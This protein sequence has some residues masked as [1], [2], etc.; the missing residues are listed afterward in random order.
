MLS[1][2]ASWFIFFVVGV[3]VGGWTLIKRRPHLAVGICAAMAIPAPTW[4]YIGQEPFAFD[5]RMALACVMLIAYCFHPLGTLRYPQH[6]LDGVVLAIIVIHIFSDVLHGGSFVATS[7]RAIGE[8]SVPYLAGR[9]A[10]LFRGG[11]TSLAP[12]FSASAI[13]LGMGALVESLTGANLWELLFSPMD[14]L[15]ERSRDLRYGLLYRAAGPTRHPIFLAIIL[16]LLLP[17]AVAQAERGTTQRLR[18]IGWLAMAMI[19][20]GMVATVSRGPL[21][22]LVLASLVATL[23]RWPR[24]RPFFAIGGVA[25]IVFLTLFGSLLITWMEKTDST[26]ERGKLVDI[27]DDTRVYTGTRNRLFVWEIYGPLVVRGGLFGFGTEAI[28]SFPPNIPGLPKTAQA[29]ETLGIVD[30]SYL[31]FGLRFGWVGLVLMIILL[32]GAIVTTI[33]QRRSAGLIFYP[34]G[35]AFATALAGVLAGVALE[36]TTVYF[37]YE[38]AYWVLFHCGVSTGLASLHRRVLNGAED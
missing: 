32:S 6:W 36:I 14:D 17:W 16:L 12:W 4:V 18:A 22:G 19:T 20:L 21:I 8:W 11:V 28:S 15:V 34:F 29:A 10:V 7:V 13:I 27:G 23:L 37:S 35:P 9:C 3:S 1:L 33:T 25:A 24:T 2:E 5:V 26:G 38:F 31:L 30:N